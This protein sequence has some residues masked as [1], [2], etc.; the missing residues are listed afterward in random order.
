M[1]TLTLL[2]IFI[3]I[4]VLKDVFDFKEINGPVLEE[5]YLKGKLYLNAQCYA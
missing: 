4:C 5:T 1:K 2:T 3:S